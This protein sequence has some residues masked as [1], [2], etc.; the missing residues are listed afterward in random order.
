MYHAPVFI[1]GHRMAVYTELEFAEIEALVAPLSLGRLV[2]AEGI[3]A[4]IENT[5]YFLDFERTTPAYQIEKF[6]LTIVESLSKPEVEFI[7]RLTTY[8]HQHGLPVPAPAPSASGATLSVR[9]KPALVIPKI[10][11]RHINS[12]SPEL[13]RNLGEVIAKLHLATSAPGFTHESH[14]SLGWV[15][16]TGSALLPCLGDA[17]Q[18]LLSTELSGLKRFVST[19]ISLRQITI[20]GDLFRDNVLIFA[21]RIVAIIDF[22]SAGTGYPLLD[23]AIAANDWCFNAEGVLNLEN[24]R[25][26]LTGYSAFNPPHAEEIGHWQEFMRLAA[27]RFWVSRLN[28]QFIPVSHAPPGRG[29]NPFPYR[30][31]LISHR[32]TPFEWLD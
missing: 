25:A 22:F 17:D 29:K 2:A 21:Q 23:V 19:N 31:L 12:A 30:E 4:G 3:A 32:N 9:G 18:H 20:H 28:E 14:R 7:A 27:L 8:L 24:Y 1:Q 5:T 16:K 26:L 10:S 6:V 11:G 13:C 15:F